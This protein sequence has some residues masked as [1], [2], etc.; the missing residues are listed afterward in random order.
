MVRRLGSTEMQKGRVSK[1]FQ[2]LTQPRGTFQK[3][4]PDCSVEDELG[5]EKPD[6]GGI[7]LEKLLPSPW[8]QRMES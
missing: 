7:F 1:S 2:L 4:S 8:R 6:G 3:G 5:V